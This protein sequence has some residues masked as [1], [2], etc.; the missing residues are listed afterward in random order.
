ML[1]N[2]VDVKNN[3]KLV[4]LDSAD[5]DTLKG[6]LK[7]NSEL[8]QDVES[9]FIEGEMDFISDIIDPIRGALYDWSIGFYNHNYINIQCGSN[10]LEG[11]EEIQ[12]NFGL[13]S[14]DDEQ[15]LKKAIELNKKLYFMDCD[16]KQ[17]EN[18]ENKIN[19][20]VEYME[21]S[22]IDNINC[23]TEVDINEL[24]EFFIEC[25]LESIDIEDYYYNTDTMELVKEVH[26]IKSYM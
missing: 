18:L 13:F 24:E 4:S 17:Y 8:Y 7:V 2:I 25:Y 5:V 14:D 15:I 1:N 20:M 19:S 9:D 26:Y 6:I 12:N 11:L 10:F 3:D 21:E 16:N 23:I 22:F